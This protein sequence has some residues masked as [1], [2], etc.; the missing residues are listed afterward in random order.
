MSI[1]F[2]KIFLIEEDYNNANFFISGHPNT[3]E[4]VKQTTSYKSFFSDTIR[5]S[6][7]NAIIRHCLFGAEGEEKDADIEWLM[8]VEAYEECAEQLDES[9]LDRDDVETLDTL[10]LN[11]HEDLE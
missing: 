7:I 10:T 6:K 5:Q 9:F 4:E 8:V 11:I 2:S 3:E 1:R